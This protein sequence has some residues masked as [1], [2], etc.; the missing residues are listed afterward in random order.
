MDTLSPPSQRLSELDSALAEKRDALTD[1]VR[2]IEAGEQTSL[3]RRDTLRSEI[4]ILE[5]RRRGIEREI[6]GEE[7]PKLIAAAAAAHEAERNAHARRNETAARRDNLEKELEQAHRDFAAA[8]LAWD[9]ARSVVYRTE[10]SL[11]NHRQQFQ[12]IEE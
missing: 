11:A 6:P 3:K 8:D 12:Q 10:T 9:S 7:R 1:E 2:K 4:E 5:I